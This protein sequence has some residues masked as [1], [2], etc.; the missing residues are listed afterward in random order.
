MDIT[1]GPSLLHSLPH[2]RDES[3]CFARILNVAERNSVIEGLSPFND[4]LWQAI[5]WDSQSILNDSAPAA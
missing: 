4:S 5:R 2:L 1:P 3:E